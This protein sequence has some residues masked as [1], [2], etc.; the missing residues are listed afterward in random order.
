MLP[1][2]AVGEKV[3]TP[4]LTLVGRN[5][6]GLVPI[7]QCAIRSWEALGMCI[8]LF[9][10]IG[11]TASSTASHY[12]EPGHTDYFVVYFVIALT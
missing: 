9:S 8:G 7:R 2:L 1:C 6:S 11:S 5:N 4:V 12:A 10:L 3:S